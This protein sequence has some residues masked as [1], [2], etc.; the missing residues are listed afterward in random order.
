M[1][2]CDN[3]YTQPDVQ[4]SS[5]GYPGNFCNEGHGNCCGTDYHTANVYYDESACG[6]IPPQGGC[7]SGL[8]WINCFCQEIPSPIVIDTTGKGFLLTAADEGVVFDI[9]GNG[10]PIK[11]GWT[12]AA[13]GNAFLA[14]DR[15][16]DGHINNGQELF[17][18]F[19]SQPKS[20][21]PNGFLALAEFDKPENGGNGDGIIDHRDAI[22][23]QLV[24]WIDENH[25]GLSQPNELHSLPELGVYSLALRYRESRRT[26]A[27]GNQ[28]RYQAAVNP[29]P[30]DGESS[31]GRFAYDVFFAFVSTSGQSPLSFETGTATDSAPHFLDERGLIFRRVSGWTP[32]CPV[33]TPSDKQRDF[34]GVQ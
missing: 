28:F 2:C 6:C 19:T 16:H 24:L 9:A 10:H 17:G 12:G 4:C 15:N 20:D 8:Y 25:D 13:S 14:L 7:P 31:D 23:S 3:T 18:N 5:G 34:G 26:D 22:F 27:F 32:K 30:S 33:Q 11:M 21:H 1:H 29:D